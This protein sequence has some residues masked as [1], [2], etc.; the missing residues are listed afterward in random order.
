VGRKSCTAGFTYAATPL[1]SRRLPRSLNFVFQAVGASVA[2]TGR[3][4]TGYSMPVQYKEH[5]KAQSI[6]DSV[7]HVRLQSTTLEI[8]HTDAHAAYQTSPLHLDMRMRDACP[9]EEMRLSC[10]DM[11]HACR[12]CSA[13]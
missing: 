7:K 5:A 4:H 1:P 9:H 2:L 3:S 8:T 11:W 13:V 6:I 10:Q 12:A